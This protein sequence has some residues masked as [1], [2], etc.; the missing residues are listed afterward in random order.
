MRLP[1]KKAEIYIGVIIAVAIFLILS[2]AIV[3]LVFS[4]YDL[5]VF[6][7]S[8]TTARFIAEEKIETARSLNFDDVGTVGG[9]P[10]GVL[11][12]T[13]VIERN[14]LNYTVNTRIDNIDDEFDGLAGTDS[15]PIDYKRIRIIVSWGGEGTLSRANSIVLMTDVS[16]PNDFGSGGGVLDIQVSDANGA[17]VSLA[18]VHITA[19]SLSPPVDTTLTA[20]SEG[21]LIVPGSA[22]CDNCY[23]ISATK[24]GFS[25]DQTYGEPDVTNPINPH[26]TV[27]ED[28]ISTVNFSI[29]QLGSLALHSTNDRDSGFTPLASQQFIL[30]GE[31]IIGTSGAGD[32]IYKYAQVLNTDGSGQLLIEDLEWDAYHVV[33]PTGV[34]W[35][36]SGTN[37]FL[38][39]VLNPGEDTSAVFSSTTGSDHTLL[40]TFQD[41]TLSPLATA[42]ALLKDNFSSFEASVSAGLVDDPDYG[43]AFFANLDNSTYTIYATASGYLEYENSDVIV[44]GYSKEQIIF[45]DE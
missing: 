39:I 16:S 12:P 42:S 6:T 26:V 14:G 30:R 7:R 19:D 1:L 10:A 28:Q 15:N 5:V 13:E 11:E 8:R 33:I 21:N 29:D 34:G 3:S 38:P 4:A 24:D 27:V 35:D 45:I 22:A 25:T 20:D 2:Q 31:K 17:P 18:E 43:Q 41:G 44:S 36:V 9:I 32:L 40:V 23:Q 37:P